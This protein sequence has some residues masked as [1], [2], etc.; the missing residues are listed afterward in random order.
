MDRREEKKVVQEK[1]EICLIKAPV[2][3]ADVQ[4]LGKFS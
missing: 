1:K 3:A 4:R 2:P